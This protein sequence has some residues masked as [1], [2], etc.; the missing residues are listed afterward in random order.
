MRHT[1]STSDSVYTLQSIGG[2]TSPQQ[3]QQQQIRSS[4]ML[5]TSTF[6]LSRDA[7][8]RTNNML[9][10]MS[11]PLSSGVNRSPQNTYF[12]NNNTNRRISG[13]GSCNNWNTYSGGSVSSG[14]EES[15][16]TTSAVIGYTPVTRL[17]RLGKDLQKLDALDLNNNNTTND[18]NNINNSSSVMMTQKPSTSVV[19]MISFQ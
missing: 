3:Q 2:G 10:S 12:N 4:N 1:S 18:N 9:Y 15:K 7:S 14:I 17:T 19:S 16:T 8:L 5:A 13:K 6:S 11:A